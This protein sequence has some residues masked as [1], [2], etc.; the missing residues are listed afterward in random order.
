M[1]LSNSE[2]VN[3][4]ATYDMI[5]SIINTP[6]TGDVRTSVNSFAPFGWVP[7]NDGTIGYSSTSGTY[8]TAR[9][10]PD[11][12]PLYNLLWNAFYQYSTGAST[13][14]TNPV[15][16]MYNTSGVSIGYGVGSTPSTAW[17]DF[18]AGNALS[19]TKAMGRVFMG[20]VPIESLLISTSSIPGY[21]TS[22]VTASYTASDSNNYLQITFGNAVNLF[23][24]M[25]FT[26][27]ADTGTLPSNLLPN[28]VYYAVPLSSSSLLISTSFEQ[29]ILV[30]GANYAGNVLTFVNNAT[31]NVTFFAE[32]LGATLGEYSHTQTIDELVSHT[33][34]P[35]APTSTFLGAGTGQSYGGGGAQ[36]GQ[37]AGTA[38]AGGG[39]S[40]NVTQP[41][42]FY[43]IFV[44][45]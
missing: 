15:L 21:K 28:Y 27:T 5:N 40:F 20:T 37:A 2:P 44:K 29:A 34:T 31:G 23:L 43:N 45:L 11:T 8:I 16:P 10:N 18:D 36:F 17:S 25:P 3:D 1:F 4:F 7:M 24:G 35:D 22:F 14:G 12:W 33:H 30:R 26:V 39:S 13:T 19:L 41:S 32:P 38:A 6:R 9:N 42:S